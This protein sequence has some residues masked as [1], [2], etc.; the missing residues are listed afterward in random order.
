MV[1]WSCCEEET[2]QGCSSVLQVGDWADVLTRFDDVSSAV[3]RWRP[4]PYEITGVFMAACFSL[5]L[6][7]IILAIVS[8]ATSQHASAE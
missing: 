2:S 1:Y 5:H 7:S 8:P 4:G 6:I 3:V